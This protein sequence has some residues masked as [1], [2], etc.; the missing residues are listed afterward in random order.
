MGVFEIAGPAEAMFRAWSVAAAYEL[1][2]FDALARPRTQ[3]ELCAAIGIEAGVHRVH[4]LARAL[5]HIGVLAREG[6]R[7]VLGDVPERPEVV[8][9]G[10]GRLAEVIRTNQPLSIGPDVRGYHEHLLRAGA[11]TARELAPLLRPGRL[12]DLGGGAGAYTAAVL[13]AHPAATCT[14]VDAADVIALAHEHLARFGDRVRLVAGDARTAPIGEGHTT[15]LLANVMHLH[16]P[17]TCAELCAVA[18]RA[19]AP[20][21]TV[22]VLDFDAASPEGVWF[23]VVMALYTEGG[24]VYPTSQLRAWLADAG[25]ADLVEHRPSAAP[26]VT[27]IVGTRVDVLSPRDEQ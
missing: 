1:G 19:V 15:A 3:G 21:G 2:M 22:V 4:A 16:D 26:A 13:D 10:W 12:L 7:I 20:G 9:E 27:V 17:A 11:E 25:L 18:A 6:D 5:V 23:A 8:R 24:G 14:L